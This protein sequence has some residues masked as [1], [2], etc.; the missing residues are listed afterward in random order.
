MILIITIVMMIDTNGNGHH[1]TDI[2]NL[3]EKRG[4]KYIISIVTFN[5][6][7]NIYTSVFITSISIIIS[8]IKPSI[9]GG[10]VNGIPKES[11]SLFKTRKAFCNNSNAL[12]SS[13]YLSYLSSSMPYK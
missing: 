9:F 3:L 5:K 6:N 4:T 2:V 8:Y 13:S 7:I 10:L 11:L 1:H 12:P